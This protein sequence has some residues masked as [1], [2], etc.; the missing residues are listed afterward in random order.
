MKK[1]AGTIYKYMVKGI[2]KL[3]IYNAITAT[4]TNGITDKI[5]TNNKKAE[6]PLSGLP[7]LI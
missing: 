1:V 3:F 2:I 4:F 7:F 5:T 6:S